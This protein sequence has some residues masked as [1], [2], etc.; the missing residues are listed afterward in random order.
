MKKYTT[1]ITTNKGTKKEISVFLDDETAKALDESNDPNITHF[2]ILEK[3][4]EDLTDL[5][6][7]R[8]HLSLENLLEKGYF[9]EN[10]DSNLSKYAEKMDTVL[11]M[12]KAL[13]T[14]TDKQFKAIWYVAVDGLS[15]V[16][17]GKLMGIRWDTVRQYYKAAEKKIKKYF[18]S[19]P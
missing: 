15:Y 1:Y 9:I 19:I 8:R 16:E 11:K 10:E 12:R 7:T 17:T 6:E 13:A 14:L 5:K 4:K 18:K 2:Y 3:H